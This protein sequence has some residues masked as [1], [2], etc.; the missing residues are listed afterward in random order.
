MRPAIALMT[1]LLLAYSPDLLACGNAME[2]EALVSHTGR[3]LFFA[4]VSGVA[5]A[6]AAALYVLRFRRSSRD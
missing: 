1:I 4:S 3:G 5:L 6:A 2:G